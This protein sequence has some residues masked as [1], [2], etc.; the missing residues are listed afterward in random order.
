MVWMNTFCD[1]VCC[2]YAQCCE[3][4][5]RQKIFNRG[6][7]HSKIWQ[8]PHWFIVFQISIWGSWSFGGL[9]DGTGCETHDTVMN[10]MIHVTYVFR[11]GSIFRPT[12][13]ARCEVPCWQQQLEC[14]WKTSELWGR[15][16]RILSQLAAD[17]V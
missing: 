12:S 6:T 11:W 4:N 15:C 13:S 17:N 1:T 14:E 10:N 2:V 3:Q 7:W 9:S 8:K 5:R 16:S